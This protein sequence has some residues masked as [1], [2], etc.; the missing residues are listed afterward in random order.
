MTQ[1]AVVLEEEDGTTDLLARL[2]LL[3]SCPGPLL[4]EVPVPLEV[5]AAERARRPT[6]CTKAMWQSEAMH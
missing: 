1:A 5:H 3:L 2:P 4:A 6:L